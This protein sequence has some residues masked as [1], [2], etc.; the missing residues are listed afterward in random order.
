MEEKVANRVLAIVK[1]RRM[2]GGEGREKGKSGRVCTVEWRRQKRNSF[3]N[4]NDIKN[5]V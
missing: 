4:G 2:C 5:R 1:K 3:C